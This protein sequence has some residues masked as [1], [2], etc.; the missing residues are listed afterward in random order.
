M[1]RSNGKIARCWRHRIEQQQSPP[2]H[3]HVSG[4][5]ARKGSSSSASTRPLLGTLSYHKL[6][7]LT[8]LVR[9][10]K[11]AGLGANVWTPQKPNIPALSDF[12]SSLFGWSGEGLLKKLNS[13]LWP[14]VAFRMF[15]LV[16]IQYVSEAFEPNKISALCC[17]QHVPKG[18]CLT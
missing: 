10:N 11:V 4:A 3:V 12:C 9:T 2:S 5:D 16:C 7:T 18:Y 13:N 8:G 6:T 17:L 14:G 15:A 1:E